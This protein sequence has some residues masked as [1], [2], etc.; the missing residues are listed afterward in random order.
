MFAEGSDLE[1]YAG[2]VLEYINCCTEYVFTHSTISVFLNQK[3]WISNNV[4]TLL[5]E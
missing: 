4:R 3:P 1:E 2:S 5:K